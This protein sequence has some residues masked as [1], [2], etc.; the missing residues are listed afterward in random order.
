M[1]K[2]IFAYSG[3]TDNLICIYYLKK[4][5]FNVITLL[6]QIGQIAYLEPLGENAVNLGATVAH[7]ADLRRKF[8]NDF[9]LPALHAQAVYDNGYLLAAALSRPLIAE[10]LVSIAEEENCFHVAHGARGIGND[11]IRFNNCI[12]NLSPHIK[13]ISP[14]QELGLKTINDDNKYIKQNKIQI[15]SGKQAPYNIE[16]NLWGVNIQFGPIGRA[17]QEPKRDS[18]IITTPAIEAPDRPRYVEIKFE[19]GIPVALDNKK[20]DLLSLIETL[21]SIGGQNAIGRVDMIENKISGE[22]IREVYEA[23]AATILYS[24]YRSLLDLLMP[25]DVLQ[26]QPMLSAKYAEL[27]YQ[28][29]CPSPLKKAL[30]KFFSEISVRITGSV[31]L[32]AYK[33]SLKIIDIK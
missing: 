8:I 16:S 20:I 11:H 23:P 28:G 2:V 3:G 12:N 32:K 5:G 9:I 10:E 4:M 26:F 15:E 18:F 6:A 7:I 19:Q 29:R 24:A 30:D 13:I 33:G 17:W 27:I 22:K 14:L 31:K 21:N 25:K 1:E